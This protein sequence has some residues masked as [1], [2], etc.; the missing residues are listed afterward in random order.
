MPSSAVNS[1]LPWA[2]V[3]VAWNPLAYA[4]NVQNPSLEPRSCTCVCVLKCISIAMP[5]PASREHFQNDVER[6]DGTGVCGVSQWPWTKVTE[7]PAAWRRGVIGP[8]ELA[9]VDFGV[10][11]L[12]LPEFRCGSLEKSTGCLL[13]GSGVRCEGGSS[14]ESSKRS[15]LA[16]ITLW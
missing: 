9:V 1:F 2:D 7:W 11:L 3:G 6:A 15:C 5:P 14:S 8:T 16:W 13:L 4:L 12:V 10:P